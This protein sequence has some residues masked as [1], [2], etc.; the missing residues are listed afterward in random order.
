MAPLSLIGLFG[1]HQIWYKSSLRAFFPA[2]AREG[3]FCQT[4]FDSQDGTVETPF[5]VTNAAE[6]PRFSSHPSVANRPYVRFYTGWP[7][8]SWN[9]HI[10]GTACI[11]DFQPRVPKDEVELMHKTAVETVKVLHKGMVGGACVIRCPCRVLVILACKTFMVYLNLPSS[12]ILR[13]VGG[14]RPYR[15]RAVGAADPHS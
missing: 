2:L 13:A 11:L 14:F 1:S 3:T 9:G 12:I 8:T 5:V 7:L 15:W 4:L 6:D 10:M